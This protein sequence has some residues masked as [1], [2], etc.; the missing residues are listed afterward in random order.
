MRQVVL[1]LA[2][3]GFVA[4]GR[5]DNKYIPANQ[6]PY[7]GAA[8]SGS[9]AGAAAHGGSSNPADANA[10]ILRLDNNNEGDGS[11]QYAF[12]TSNSIAA[13]EQGHDAGDGNNAQG[14]FS[15]VSPEGEH[16]SISYS[17]GQEGFQPQGAHLPTAP[18]IPEEILKALEQNAADEARGIV[19]DGQ[20]R[21]EHEGPGAG[22]YGGAAAGGYAGAGGNNAGYKY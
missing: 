14:S 9:Y 4:C 17:A 21:P 7:Q 6:G 2:L 18:P 12:E 13:Q 20:Y 16:I 15:Y 11:Y 10:H 22:G 19:D 1:A 8:S 5:L 3:F